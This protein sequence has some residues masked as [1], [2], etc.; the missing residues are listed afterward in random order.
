MRT[1]PNNIR[2]VFSLRESSWRWCQFSS[3]QPMLWHGHL[4][5][6]WPSAPLPG[7]SLASVCFAQAFAIWRGHCEPIEIER[8]PLDSSSSSPTA[9]NTCDSSTA[10]R[11]WSPW[12]GTASCKRRTSGCIAF[13][14]SGTAHDG[15][16]WGIALQCGP[17]AMAEHFRTI[18]ACTSNDCKRNSS[19]LA[20][21]AH[22]AGQPFPYTFV[23]LSL[24]DF[25]VWNWICKS[26][27]CTRVYGPQELFHLEKFT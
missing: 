25:F 2:T 21:A 14:S 5:L 1:N 12:N 22:A 20:A 6:Q 15:N 23:C 24:F 13:C 19:V 4:S 9:R 7:I 3:V 11:F 10:C 17:H 8:S 27:R 16:W 18:W 26:I